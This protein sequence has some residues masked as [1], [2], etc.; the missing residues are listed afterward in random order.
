MQSVL[1]AA[2]IVSPPNGSVAD[3]FAA[4]GV[5]RRFALDGA[6]LERRFYQLSRE[7]HPDRFTLQS[8]ETRQLALER[9]S[10]VNE[11]Y[12]VLKNPAL[13]RHH[14]LE[15]EGLDPQGSQGAQKS[16]IPLELAESWFELQDA[17]SEDP[18]NA[19]SRLSTFEEEFRALRASQEER[20]EAL[21][22]EADAVTPELI[23]ERRARLARVAEALRSLSYLAS[24]ER[25]IGRIRARL[26]A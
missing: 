23:A 5:E 24:M 10:L 14:L 13:R 15:L 18:G 2:G 22:R 16:M 8:A 9:M 25:D 11:A 17:L 12:R 3:Y 6:E 26:S 4:L 20:I 19:I 21:T 1:V 7:L